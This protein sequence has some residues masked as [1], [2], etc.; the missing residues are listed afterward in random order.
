[1]GHKGVSKRKPKKVGSLSNVNT[2]S[3]NNSP[4][5]SL[6]KNNEAVFDKGNLNTVG[7]SSKNKKGK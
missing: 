7:P 3:K 1:M 4:V 2:P 6:V 5:Q